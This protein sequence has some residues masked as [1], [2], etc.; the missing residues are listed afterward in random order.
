MTSASS[1]AIIRA[2]SPIECAPVEQAVTTAWLG[3]ISPYLIET[4]PEI[5]L[6]SRPWTKCGETRRGPFSCEDQRFLLDPRQPADA[7][8]DRDA[9]AEALLL[10]HVGEAGILD[11][12]AGGVEAVDDERIDLALDLV[13][14]A[15][16]GIEAVFVLGRLDLAG[17]LAG[18]VGRVEAGDRRRPALAGEDV[19]PGRLDVTA[20]RGDEA[21]SGYDHSAHSH[22]S[23]TKQAQ[24]AAGP[25]LSEARQPSARSW[26]AARD[27][28]GLALVLFDVA[29][30]VADGVDLLGRVVGNL[31]AELFLEGHHQL[32]DVEAVGA[33][34]VDE[35]RVGRDLVF[36]D[37]EVLDNDLLHAVGGVAHVL[38]SR[39]RG[40]ICCRPNE[41]RRGW[42]VPCRGVRRA[43]Q[44]NVQDGAAASSCAF[45]RQRAVNS[46]HAL[47]RVVDVSPAARIT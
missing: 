47:P 37:A 30:G 26:A 10:A 2:A 12:L 17:D 20:Q 31:D 13:I 36:L 27:V 42:Q 18:V 45:A 44:G 16:V 7:R 40:W 8:A 39:S 25:S 11:R 29:V 28:A 9:G 15:L 38:P 41:R 5:R 35:A 19:G 34:I 4:W 21:Q 32:D 24:P 1:I 33:Q 23:E 6:I 3:P 22:L 46:R 43:T 14:D